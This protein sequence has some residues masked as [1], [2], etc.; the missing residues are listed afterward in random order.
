MD[1]QIR[2]PLAY[3]RLLR[4]W[5]QPGLARRIRQAA[6]RRGLRSGVDRQRVWKWETGRALPDEESQLLL[7]DVFAV[8]PDAVRALGWPYW[9]PGRDAVLELGPDSAVHA[10][11]EALSQLIDRRSFVAFTPAALTGLALQW[12]ERDPHSPLTQ[13]RGDHVDA[14]I[15]EGLERHGAWLN[16]LPTEQ[17]QHLGPLLTGHLDTI[18]GLI[19]QG[20]Y[21]A[22]V[23][24]RLHTLAA[25]TAQTA[26]WHRFDH[27][28]HAAASHLWHG[29]LH[30]AHAAGDHDLGA[31]ILSDLAYQQT[32]LHD[33]RTAVQI[34]EHAIARAEHPTAQSLLQLRKARAHAALGEELACTRALGAA[35]KFFDSATG[36]PPPTWCSWH[37]TTDIAVDTGRCLLDLG[38]HRRARQLIDEGT[39]MLPEARLKTRA[40]FLT[41]EAES[42]IASGSIDQ[43]AATAH[44]ALTM[45]RRIGAPRCISLIQD[46]M[47]SFTGKRTV[48]GVPELLELVRAS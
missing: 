39:S 14:G 46:L 5:T 13:L 30:S 16:S 38:H 19:D 26:A 43:A 41:Y 47:P 1:K 31:G 4:C 25:T 48:E 22:A 2:H 6:A 44:Q 34:L 17:R 28:R 21:T 35:E 24:K 33:P 32:W 42:L 9:L 29:A 37:A 11:R 20:R 45:A 15:V 8:S 7:A 40:V 23:G 3:A 27:G 10:L 36:T 12:A 18:T